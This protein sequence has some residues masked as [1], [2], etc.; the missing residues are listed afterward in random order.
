MSLNFKEE[1]IKLKKEKNALILCHLYAPKEIQE[2]ADYVGDSYY[3]SVIGKKSINNILV[4]CGVDFMAENAKI[5]SPNK[6]ILNPS[7]NGTCPMAGMVSKDDILNF[8]NSNPNTKIVCYVNSSSDVKSVCDVCCTS[9]SAVKIINNLETNDILFVPD[10][11]LGSYVSKK[12]SS[13]NIQLWHGYC[14]IHDKISLHDINEFKKN[15]P[16][17]TFKILVH[18]ECNEDIR[19]I[20]HYIGSTK[21]ILDFVNTDDSKN[22]LIITECGVK[23]PLENRYPDK[24]FYFLDM[25]CHNMK[26]LNLMSLY[27]TLKNLNNEVVLSEEV[28]IK[29]SKA[30]D[31]MLLYSK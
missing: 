22:Y 11:N 16:N 1:I 10:K 2:V 30:L 26:K 4:V 7:P 19:N 29:A 3:L 17:I 31:N 27:N 23:Y 9:S 20:A 14:P 15:M 18:P 28:I 6:K 25:T 12:I 5:L 13:K 21:E 24:N 8:K